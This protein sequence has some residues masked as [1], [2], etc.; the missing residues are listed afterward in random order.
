LHPRPSRRQGRCEVAGSMVRLFVMPSASK[1]ASVSCTTRRYGREGRLAWPR[2]GV[3]VCAWRCRTTAS[4]SK[5][6][7]GSQTA[8]RG[9]RNRTLGHFSIRAH[10]LCHLPARKIQQYSALCATE[11]RPAWQEYDRH[12]CTTE[13]PPSR[14]RQPQR[15]TLISRLSQ[16]RAV[17]GAIGVEVDENG[18][19]L[20][21]EGALRR[22]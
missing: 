15:F 11:S 5:A 14:R 10:R 3:G 9:H 20:V 17:G 2:A 1:R 4:P 8:W 16:R 19:G 6:R 22:R 18:A 13:L 7:S 12:A 21:E